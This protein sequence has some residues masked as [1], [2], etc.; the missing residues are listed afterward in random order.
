MKINF[1][2]IMVVLTTVLVITVNV[3]ANTLPLN[4]LNT[5][6]ISDSF[7]VYF[8]PA[9]YVFSIWG[10]IYIGLILFAIYQ[11]SPKRIENPRFVRIG[12][13][14]V[15]GNLANAAWIFFWHYQFFG[16]SL[17]A[18][19]TLLISLLFT[20]EGLRKKNDDPT[21]SEFWFASV[22]FSIYLGWISVATIANFSNVL[23]YYG[24]NQFGI[25]AEAWMLIILAVVVALAWAMS[26][27]RQDV[28]YLM[29]LLWAIFGITVKFPAVEIVTAGIW[30]S[31]IL[32]ALAFIYAIY[33]RLR[34]K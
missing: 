6:E 34:T 9:G 15:L 33:L 12:Y 25:S 19:L 27:R 30:V 3:L 23:Y 22:P 32:I 17:V 11:A 2:Q 5:G 28:A 18:M 26:I 10:V 1:R 24:W 20:Y 4:G 31:F 21:P 16:W 29:V 13:W 7:D 8:I 14:V